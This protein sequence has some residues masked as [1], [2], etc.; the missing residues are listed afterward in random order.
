MP[1]VKR[2]TRPIPSIRSSESMLELNDYSGGMNNYVSNDKFP[3]KDGGANMWRMAQDARINTLGEYDS[4]QGFDYHSAAAGETMDDS[5]T[6]TT[7]AGNQSFSNTI[8]LA[9]QFVPVQSGR[10]SRLDIRLKNANTASGTVLVELWSDASNLPSAFVART[11]I[12]SSSITSSYAYLEAR[13]PDAPTITGGVAYWIVIYTQSVAISTYNCSSTTASGGSLSSTNSGSSWTSITGTS[14]NFKQYY[15]TNSET[16]GLFRAYKSDGTKVTLLAHGTVLY[17]VDNVTGALT[18]IKTG[19]NASATRYRFVLINDIVYYCNSYDGLR[20]WNFT[21]ESQVNTTNYSILAHHKG[22]LFGVRVDEP[23]RADF[24]NFGEYEVFTSTD[25][26]YAIGPK[27][28]DP[29]TALVSLNGYLVMKCLNNTCIL[30]GDDNATFDV[31]EAPDQN[32]TYTQE[33]ITSDANFMYYLADNGLYRSN[34]SEAQLLSENIYEEIRT[35]QNKADC[36][37]AINKGRLYLWYKSPGAS[38]NDSCYVWN[39]NYSSGGRDSV[40]S[41]DTNAYVCRAV[42]AFQDGDEMLVA[43]SLIGQV[44]WQE[45][46]SNDNTNLGG[47]I[48]FQLQSHYFTFSTPAALKQNRQWLPRFGSQSA[49]YTVDCQFASDL[50]D[51]WQT[52]DSTNLQGSGTLWGSG[53]LWGAFT[54]GRTAEVQASLYI[55]GEYRRI[56]I[57]YKHFATRQPVSFLGH[58]LRMQTR[59]IK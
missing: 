58:T 4:R 37:I 35:L 43:S 23:T 21:T 3:V 29:I 13:F 45:K 57:R 34:A 18:S 7:G 1:T 33:T 42:D 11:S 54:W 20:K 44:Y 59:R 12:A 28:G 8:R 32:G 41:H 17:S 6:A 10:L 16:K 47:D 19:L 46:A 27:T 48:Q 9:Q 39:L 15:A 50:R 55:P 22:L 31:E 51:N 24:S 26:V 56:A 49:S 38:H 25:F 52:V 36:C 53:V 2:N 14:L 30:S 40:E 5:E